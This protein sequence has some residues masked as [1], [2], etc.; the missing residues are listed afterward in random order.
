ML[1]PFRVGF[2]LAL[3]RGERAAWP[4]TPPCL[5]LLGHCLAL[6]LGVLG[7]R[8]AT[9][10]GPCSTMFLNKSPT[11]S[12][13]LSFI[14]SVGEVIASASVVLWSRSSGHQQRR[15]CVASYGLSLFFRSFSPPRS[16][17]G[18]RV[19]FMAPETSKPVECRSPSRGGGRQYPWTAGKL[20]ICS[21]V[22]QHGVHDG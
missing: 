12:Q 4:L 15:P 14:N 1:R 16:K 2:P 21:A 9:G 10:H 20:R 6:F 13:I 19:K 17:N 18:S 7:F 8:P 3:S 5:A 11:L 22:P